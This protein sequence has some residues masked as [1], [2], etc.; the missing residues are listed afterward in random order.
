MKNNSTN[1]FRLYFEKK[2]KIPKIRRYSNHQLRSEDWSINDIYHR[3]DGPAYREW[4][5]NG[6]P[7]CE[8]WVKNNK[9][10]RIGGPAYQSWTED[11][12]VWAKE[13]YLNGKPYTEINYWKKLFKMS[14]QGKV[15]KTTDIVVNGLTALI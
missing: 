2:E 7:E 5:E 3:L 1:T 4:Y 6:Q 11:G 14:E 12:R 8:S 10:H 9:P 13:Y 15:E